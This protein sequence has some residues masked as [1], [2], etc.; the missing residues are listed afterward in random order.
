MLRTHYQKSMSY[1][2]SNSFKTID[3][4]TSLRNISQEYELSVSSLHPF[5]APFTDDA[6][7][8]LLS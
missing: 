6:Q 4:F 5:F 7:L 3:S 8:K 1:K 2:N